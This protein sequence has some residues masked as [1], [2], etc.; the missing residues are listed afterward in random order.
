MNNYQPEVDI[1]VKHYLGTP[2]AVA[3]V[4]VTAGPDRTIAGGSTYDLTSATGV[5]AFAASVSSDPSKV[6]AVE[7]MIGAQSYLEDRDDLAHVVLVYANCEKDGADRMSRVVLSGHSYRG[8]VYN[9][10]GARLLSKGHIW[11]KN[12]VD[13]ANTFPKAAAQTT[14]LIILACVA[15]AEEDIKNYY[16]M[17]FPNLRTVWGW[18]GTCPTGADAA[19]TLEGW[20]TTTDRGPMRLPLPPAGQANWSQVTGDYQTGDQ[21]D[22]A[23]LLTSL[24]SDEPTFNQYLAGAK[25]DPD[26]HVGFLVGFYTRAQ[27]A[28]GSV[29]LPEPDKHYASRLSA[30]SLL[31]RFWPK[32]ISKF[33]TM[34]KSVV[35]KGYG[36][37]PTPDYGALSRL[38]ALA[39]IAKFSSDA[40]GA[41]I[42]KTEAQRLLTAL[43]DLDNSVIGPSF[44]E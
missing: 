4:T 12:L 3:K 28:A 27:R 5:K 37:A 11:F 31:L 40:N 19:A 33:W 14:H 9:D 36:T 17:A 39:E 24:R 38:A 22:A 20:L 29:A 43:R 13:L 6:A 44:I 42:D 23:T 41:I 32:V 15:G 16:L 18:T 25:V 2:V 10:P 26:A 34:Y 21:L 8:V 30:Q 35:A 7:I 1:L